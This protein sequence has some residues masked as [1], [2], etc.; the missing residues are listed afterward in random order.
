MFSNGQP[1]QQRV[2]LEDDAAL[3]A[4]SLIGTPSRQDLA[5]VR[6]HEAGDQRHQGGLPGA[7]VADDG[8]ELALLHGEVDP[9]ST[10]SAP[11]VFRSSCGRLAPRGKP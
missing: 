1:G 8:D 7:G 3:G 10:R 2:L 9:L 11:R 6:C 4:R 5:R